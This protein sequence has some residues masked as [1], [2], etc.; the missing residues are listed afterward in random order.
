MTSV[1][2]VETEIPDFTSLISG[3][4]DLLAISDFS[5]PFLANGLC[6]RLFL[7]VTFIE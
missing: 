5:L 6:Y 4:H 2:R 3:V 7:C 1:R